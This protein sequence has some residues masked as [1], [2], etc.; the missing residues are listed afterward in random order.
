[1]IHRTT[2]DFIDILTFEAPDG[3]M[4]SIEDIEYL[5]NYVDQAEKNTNLNGLILTGQG[6]SFSTGLNTT[7]IIEQC[8]K[9]QINYFF[10]SFDI[11][12]L[13]LFSFP[14]PVVA[15]INGHSIGGGLLIQSC[16]DQVFIADNEKIKIGLPELK[17]GLTIDALMINLL[18]YSV[19]NS[20]V[21]SKMIY[22]ASYFDPKQSI[23][24]GLADE[25]F[26]QEGL[27][28]K[29][30]SFIQKMQEQSVA[31]SLTKQIIKSD[32]K[33]KMQLAL[34]NNCYQTLSHLLTLKFLGND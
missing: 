30:I 29:C 11:L 5:L 32:Y 23:K 25:I 2:I 14:K 20:K 34:N 22:S 27:I 3:N 8:T 28:E 13:R 9:D 24:Y 15:A 1:M 17:L 6:R 7:S 12:L 26:P 19:A 18:N 16:A 4:L 33:D 21:L 31:F 10:K